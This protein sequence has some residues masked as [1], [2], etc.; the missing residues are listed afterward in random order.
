[1]NQTYRIQKYFRKY[2]FDSTSFLILRK[3]SMAERTPAV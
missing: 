1:M 3:S 2:L